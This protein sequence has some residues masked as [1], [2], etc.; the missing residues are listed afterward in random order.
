ML[1][2]F[3]R[4]FRVLCVVAITVLFLVFAISNRAPVHLSLFP[5]PY[6][7]DLP[8]FLLAIACFSLGV[9]VGGITMGIK[10][11]QSWRAA[12]QEHKRAEALENELSALHGQHPSIPAIANK[13]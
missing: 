6:D 1:G 4:G 7:A 5:L 2:A 3:R 8:L 10:L 12:R 9:L 13:A 11:S